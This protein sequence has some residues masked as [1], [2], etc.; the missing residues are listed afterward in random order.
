MTRIS[1]LSR[2]QSKACSNGFTLVEMLVVLAI[3]SLA[4]VLFI[5]GVNQSGTIARME[6]TELERSITSARQSAIRSGE[7]RRLELVPNG[8][9]L[10]GALAGE[11]NLLFYAD[12]SSNGGKIYRDEQLVAQVRW[13]DGRLMR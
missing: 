12:G 3:M 13:I 2:K 8:F 4:A 7:T 9:K 10:R 5:G 1:K 11:D 6:V